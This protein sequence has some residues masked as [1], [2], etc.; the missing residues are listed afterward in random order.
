VEHRFK[1]SEVTDKKF[2]KNLLQ[3]MQAAKPLNDFLK[4]ALD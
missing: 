1:D 2:Q 4:Q 3:V